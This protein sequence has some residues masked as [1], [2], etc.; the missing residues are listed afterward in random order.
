VSFSSVSIL[1]GSK[2][3]FGVPSFTQNARRRKEGKE[4]EVVREKRKVVR[5]KRE[6]VKR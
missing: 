2:F 5:G 4:E 1:P 3:T 6:D